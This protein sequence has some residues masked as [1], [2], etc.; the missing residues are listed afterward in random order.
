MKYPWLNRVILPVAILVVYFLVPINAEDA[1]IGLVAGIVIS[2]LGLVAIGLII[3]DEVRRSQK[4]LRLIHLLLALE[5]V[6]V[7]FAFSYY[8]LAFNR[9]DEFNGLVTRLDALYF[10]TS[11]MTTVGF[12]D[13]SAAGQIGRGLVTGQMVFSLAF[14]AAL[15]NLFQ[16]GLQHAPAPT[17]AHRRRRVGRGAAEDA[18]AD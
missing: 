6:L 8:L 18:P 1:P 9:P 15:L 13:V 2:L 11:T 7:I 10:S 17:G 14:I 4:R 16:E 5:L 12:G 3:L